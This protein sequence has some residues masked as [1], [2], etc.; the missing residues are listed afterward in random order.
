MRSE[1]LSFADGTGAIDL[2]VAWIHG[3]E[4][5]E[6][7]TDP[8]IQ[9]HALDEHT[10]ILRQNM[11]VNFEAPFV[12]LL[13]G[14]SQALLL[15]TGATAEPQFFPLRRTV[16]TIIDR[17]LARHPHAGEYGLQVL[18]T[19]SHHDHRAAD[20]QL[21]DRPST[22]LVDAAREPAWRYFGFDLNPEAVV[23]LDL[24]GRI[25]DCFSTPGH[26]ESAVTYY[27]R[28]TRLLFTG[29]TFYPGR[30]YVIDWSAFLRSIDRLTGWC[31]D[32]P[33]AFLLGC[34]IEMTTTP[35]VDYPA[36]A[37]WQPE[38]S[39]LELTVDHLRE[40]QKTLSGHQGRRDRYTLP[41]LIVV[42]ID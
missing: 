41:Q 9:V 11:A 32:H 22:L 31:S 25:L 28:Y 30:L 8:D 2:D 4:S 27:D 6:Q 29:D 24:G 10:Y 7:N 21:A 38:E 36:G 16:D 26:D 3:S 5:A 17:W 1:D 39:P 35:G 15:D 13:F 23:A 14:R 40:L 42:P 33:V 34:H 20:A 18:H 19:H 12:F 37:T